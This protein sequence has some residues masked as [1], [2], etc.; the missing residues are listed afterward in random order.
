METKHQKIPLTLAVQLSYAF[1]ANL[2]RKLKPESE[3]SGSFR[4]LLFELATLQGCQVA[5]ILWG[6]HIPDIG[7][8]STV[9]N[10]PDMPNIT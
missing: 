7:S 5:P 3:D 8:C 10:I 6:I 9:S 1:V 4:A 2:H